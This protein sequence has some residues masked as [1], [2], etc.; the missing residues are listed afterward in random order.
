MIQYI[1]PFENKVFSNYKTNNFKHAQINPSTG[2]FASQF[3]L[4]FGVLSILILLF[5]SLFLF[6]R[7]P[8]LVEETLD[9]TE[10]EIGEIEISPIDITNTK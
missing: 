8:D 1:N 7:K 9:S 5:G 3:A 4:F 10:K 2:S 6:F